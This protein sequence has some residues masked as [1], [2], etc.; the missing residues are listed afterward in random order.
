MGNL[1]KSIVGIEQLYGI[2]NDV[3]VS[4]SGEIV[5]V[6]DYGEILIFRV[7]G[8]RLRGMEDEVKKWM[9]GGDWMDGSVFRK[10]EGD[11]GTGLLGSV[12]DSVKLRGS[13]GSNYRGSIELPNVDI[14][15]KNNMNDQSIFNP[16]DILKQAKN[17]YNQIDSIE[18]KNNSNADN[19]QQAKL[20]LKD[21]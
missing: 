5:C 2:V 7:G 1:G 15:Y 6:G 17:I 13:V 9:G 3:A 8:D 21:K 11:G 10:R 12:V 19:S 20:E 16:M 18:K 4:E 14:E